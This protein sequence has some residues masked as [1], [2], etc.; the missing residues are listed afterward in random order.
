MS[1]CTQVLSGTIRNVFSNIQQCIAFIRPEILLFYDTIK[2]CE[3]QILII[4]MNVFS[5]PQHIFGVFCCALFH[6]FCFLGRFYHKSIVIFSLKAFMLSLQRLMAKV[7]KSSGF[8]LKYVQEIPISF[9]GLHFYREFLYLI[10]S[11]SAQLAFYLS[12]FCAYTSMIS[13]ESVK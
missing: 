1:W 3:L 2:T 6:L 11:G 9:V 13:I 8:S 10:L 5:T 12:L 7:Q 4:T